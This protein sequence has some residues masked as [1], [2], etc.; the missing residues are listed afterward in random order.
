MIRHSGNASNNIRIG[1]C[2]RIRPCEMRILKDFPIETIIRQHAVNR[3][4]HMGELP[5]EFYQKLEDALLDLLTIRCDF[6]QPPNLRFNY[7][8]ITVLDSDFYS[9]HPILSK[10]TMYD[11]TTSFRTDLFGSEN[12]RRRFNELYGG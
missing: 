2:L 10:Y 6:Q 12:L 7:A 5:I 8:R 3:K 1:T 4:G 11:L 9:V